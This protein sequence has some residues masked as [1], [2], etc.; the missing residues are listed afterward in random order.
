MKNVNSSYIAVCTLLLKKAKE[1]LDLDLITR[2]E[3]DN[4]KAELSKFIQ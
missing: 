4:L 2:E 3:Y 1:K